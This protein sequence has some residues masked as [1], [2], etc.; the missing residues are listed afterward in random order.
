M[1]KR[2][3]PSRAELSEEPSPEDAREL[4]RLLRLIRGRGSAADWE[5]LVGKEDGRSPR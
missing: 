3:K 1:A 5:P 2:P 4:E